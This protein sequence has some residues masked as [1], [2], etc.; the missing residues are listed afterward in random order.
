MVEICFNTELELLQVE[1]DSKWFLKL[2][3]TLFSV[4]KEY[5]GEVFKVEFTL[6][7][8]DKQ[9]KIVVKGSPLYQCW[10][11]EQEQNILH[12]INRLYV[13]TF[14]GRYQILGEENNK[15]VYITYPIA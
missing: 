1:L 6:I 15:R 11:D 4:P 8:E 10:K 3:T 5:T 12:N 2:L 7:E 13:E 14:K 9:L